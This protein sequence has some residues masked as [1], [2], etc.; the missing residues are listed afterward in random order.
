MKSVEASG[1]TREEAIKNALDELGVEMYEADK[2]E[3][4]DEGS[5]GILGF[6]SRPVKVKVIVEHLSDDPEPRTNARDQGRNRQQ[7][8]RDQNRGE[9]R[10]RTDRPGRP[11]RPSTKSASRGGR[12][13]SR[14]DRNRKDAADGNKQES[15]RDEKPRNARGG[16]RKRSEQSRN[17]RPK[18]DDR[19][20]DD[21]RSRGRDRK[22]RDTEKAASAPPS[23]AQENRPPRR[24]EEPSVPISDDQGKT[25]ATILEEL[26]GKMGITAAVEFQRTDD[27]N[28][29]LDVTSEDGAILIGRKGRNLGALQY[30][31][32]RMVSRNDTADNS[33]RLVVD[34][35][36]YVGRRQSTLE[37]MARDFARKAKEAKR[38]MRLKPLSPQERRIIHVTL[39]EDT[40]IRTYSLGDSLYRS[41]VISP[42]N[43]SSDGDRPPRSRGRGGRG[44]G[45]GGGRS[46]RD[47]SEMDAGQFGD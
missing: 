43:A 32:N 3:I 35:E 22:P 6:G 26:I 44:R 42:K 17:D 7:S 20:R 30:L 14:D 10:A 21:N 25:A 1:P 40:E 47:D 36:G 29:R 13:R 24:A 37:D 18:R 34:I 8:G 23:N 39:R 9:G 4:L 27:D 15:S 12:D 28:A 46:Q 11:D 33:E 16:E 45:G 41:V 38:D 19:Q 31:V 5:K 2:I